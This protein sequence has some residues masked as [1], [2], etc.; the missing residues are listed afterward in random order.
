MTQFFVCVVFFA[1]T[2][3]REI[4]K[5]AFGKALF[6][7]FAEKKIG[8]QWPCVRLFVL[9]LNMAYC[10]IFVLGRSDL[11]VSALDFRSE[12]Q[13]F[14]TQSLPSGCFLRKPHIFSLHPGV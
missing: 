10:F 11:V 7:R 14:E 1:K 4:E 6:S 5:L 9:Q 12:G 8:C 2:Y 13:W 3:L